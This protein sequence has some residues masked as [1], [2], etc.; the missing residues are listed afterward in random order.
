M[1]PKRADKLPALRSLA[2]A[3]SLVLTS[4]VPA[5]DWPQLLGPTRNGIYSGND[6][7]GHWLKEGPPILWQRQVGPGF[8]GPAV[9]AGKLILFHR[10]ENREVVECLDAG[11]G[12]ALWTFGYP[13]AYRDDFGFDEGP[14]A[15]PTINDGRVF[16]YGA[17]GKL[18]CL[19]LATGKKLWALDARTEFQAPKGFFGITC[20]PLVEGDVLL[21][22]VGGKSG[23][24]IVAF[25]KASGKVLWRATD[26]EA[27]YSSPVAASFGNRRLAL[28]LTRSELV[29]LEPS[30]GKIAFR[31]GFQPPIRSSVTAAVPLVIHDLIFLS[32]SYGTGATLL[33]VKENGSGVEKLWSNDDALSNHYATSVHHNG[34]L[35]GIHGRTDPGFQPGASLRCIELKT[36]KVR[37]QQDDFGAAT[38]TLAGSDVLLLTE[39]GELV[40]APA[41]PEGFKPA[42]RVQVLPNQV[43]AYPALA[44]GRFYARSKDKLVCLGLRK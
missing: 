14:R 18:T 24:G 16:T 28:V 27:S 40:R 7:A 6:L 32:A 36:G 26:D 15:T 29:A 17:E 13:T 30:G 1:T 12:K 21:L 25:D 41:S 8:S 20:S 39:R 22:N 19:E 23:S 42:A 38:L 43:R 5:S 2:L 35:Y 31:F 11:T 44:D 4:S 9:T 3:L 33:Q 34:F 37:W 10:V